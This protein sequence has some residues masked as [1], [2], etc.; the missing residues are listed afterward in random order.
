MTALQQ[1][2]KQ[3]GNQLKFAD[4]LGISPGHLTNIIKGKRRITAEMAIR[5]EV[6]TGVSR[7]DLRPDLFGNAA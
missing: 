5:I 2:I 3:T 4:L 1:A 7:A 6:A